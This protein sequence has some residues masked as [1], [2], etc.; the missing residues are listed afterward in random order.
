MSGINN[1]IDPGPRIGHVHL[2]V[3]DLDRA[4]AFYQGVL[5]FD[6]TQRMGRGAGATTTTSASTPGRAAMDR[7]RPREARGCVTSRS[8]TQ[9]VVPSLKHWNA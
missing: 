2:R 4:L 1:P 9:P 8:S 3:A 7:R 6:I 5:G